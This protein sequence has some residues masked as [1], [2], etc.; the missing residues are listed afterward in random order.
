MASSSLAE[1]VLKSL[2]FRRAMG[3]ASGTAT[4][5]VSLFALFE[6]LM[7][8]ANHEANQQGRSRWAVVSDKV[9]LLG[10]LI[11]SYASGEYRAIPWQS[12]VSIVG[13]LIY[14]V[15]PIDLIPD[16]LPLIGLADDVALTLWLFRSLGK[17]I[18]AFEAWEKAR[19]VSI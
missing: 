4:K 17:D 9:S 7:S 16:F 3:K 2:F 12:L 19:T 10:R 14:I 8:K 6:A 11:K 13:V 1:R 15:N 18:A 5:A